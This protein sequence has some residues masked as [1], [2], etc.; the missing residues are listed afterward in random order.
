VGWRV[1]DLSGKIHF[2]HDVIFNELSVGRRTCLAHVLPSLF[3][4]ESLMW[5]V[6]TWPSLWIFLLLCS[7]Q[8]R[9]LSVIAHGW[10]LSLFWLPLIRNF[11]LPTMYL[12]LS[13]SLTQWIRVPFLFPPLSQMLLCLRLFHLPASGI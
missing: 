6:M 4:N 11:L 12:L 8:A 5:L 7:K 9:L 10:R 2:S 1:R 13:I 3:A